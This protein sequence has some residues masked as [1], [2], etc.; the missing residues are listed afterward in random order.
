[1]P[2]TQKSAAQQSYDA[3]IVR[4]NTIKLQNALER[5]CVA[6]MLNRCEFWGELAV[7]TVASKSDS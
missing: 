6:S 3:T 2:S 5:I 1:M 4:L 7:I